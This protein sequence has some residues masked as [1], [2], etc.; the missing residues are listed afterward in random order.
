MSKVQPCTLGRAHLRH[1]LHRG[2]FGK[3]W[4][5]TFCDRQ[6]CGASITRIYARL[7]PPRTSALRQAIFKKY[8]VGT[9]ILTLGLEESKFPFV[10]RTADSAEAKL[11][12]PLLS[13]VWLVPHW[14]HN[15]IAAGGNLRVIVTEKS[16]PGMRD[17]ASGAGGKFRYV[18]VE[19]SI[20]G[21]EKITKCALYRKPNARGVITLEELHR[22]GFT[23]CSNDINQGRGG[24]FLYQTAVPD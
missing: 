21:R 17:L 7:L 19:R 9:Q 23:C 14:T 2:R 18:T 1:V 4:I 11:T 22:A 3:I 5:S 12:P 8:M 6:T 24:D 15:T 20:G 16:V 13:Y 10:V